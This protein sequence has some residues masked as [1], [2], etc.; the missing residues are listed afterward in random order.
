MSR[1]PILDFGARAGEKGASIGAA[2]SVGM[3]VWK[4]LFSYG[5]E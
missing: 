1:W 2:T 5:S 3:V 4:L